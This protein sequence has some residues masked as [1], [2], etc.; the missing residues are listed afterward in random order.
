VTD[1]AAQSVTITVTATHPDATFAS[2]EQLS[3][4]RATPAPEDEPV[5]RSGP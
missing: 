3:L 4:R 2:S 5:P 1:V